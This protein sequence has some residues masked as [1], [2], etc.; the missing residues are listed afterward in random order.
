M[1]IRCQS[2]WRNSTA[3]GIAMATA[4]DPKMRN[5][6]RN[7]ATN[8]WTTQRDAKDGKFVIPYQI[9]GNFSQSELE[10][11][12]M[13]MQKIA[14]NTCV[15]FQSK[16][17]R[18]DEDFVDIQNE[19]GQGCFTS[20][21]RAPGRNILML[22]GTVGET[23]VT[24]A[25]VLHELF[26]K[27]GLWHEHMR[28]DRDKFIRVQFRNIPFYL[29]AQFRTVTTEKAITYG[30]R[31]DY[32][33]LMQYGPNAFARPSDA[34]SIKTRKRKFQKVIGTAVD[35]SRGDWIKICAIYRCS[36]CMGHKFDLAKESEQRALWKIA[37]C[38]P[39]S[40]CRPD[41]SICDLPQ[42]RALPHV[43]K[44]DCCGRCARREGN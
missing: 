19:Y 33:S 24:D 1:A 37:C 32:R 26:H 7:N 20:V 8:R 29:H 15:K 16:R 36:E 27:L 21:G 23:C 10:V 28:S 34:V 25:T 31:Y 22:E 13:A 17:N 42:A 35:A 30:V 12:F 9:S 4:M 41:A 40:E 44:Y 43:F 18:G 3:R 11:I 5:A 6:L 14:R 38:E 39:C 2:I